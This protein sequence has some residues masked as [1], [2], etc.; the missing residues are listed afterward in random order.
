MRARGE[1]KL[2]EALA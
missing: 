2:G 1:G